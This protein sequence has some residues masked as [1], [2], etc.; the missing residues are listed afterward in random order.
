[1]RTITKALKITWI[2]IPE[3]TVWT[4]SSLT[5]S[6]L[7]LGF[8]PPLAGLTAYYSATKTNS[9]FLKILAIVSTFVG[10]G[11]GALS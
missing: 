6:A 1:M 7:A 9:Y 11:I 10:I 4:M 3:Q 8:L 5:M 2:T